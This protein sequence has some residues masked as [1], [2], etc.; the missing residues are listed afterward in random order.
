MDL[1]FDKINAQMLKETKNGSNRIY[2]VYDDEVVFFFFLNY[3]SYVYEPQNKSIYLNTYIKIAENI[4]NCIFD[5]TQVNK[6]DVL[7]V[8]VQ[9][10]GVQRITEY[11]MSNT[12]NPTLTPT[13]ITT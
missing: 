2:E 1:Q 11:V 5:V 12:T 3:N 6:Q 13:P 4:D 10:N 9:I 7:I 8:T